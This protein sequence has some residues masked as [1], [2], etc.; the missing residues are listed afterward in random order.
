MFRDCP[1]VEDLWSSP[2]TLLSAVLTLWI[3]KNIS[4]LDNFASVSS[5]ISFNL[6]K[7]QWDL[8]NNY[9][10]NDSCSYGIVI[11]RH[12]KDERIIQWR[13]SPIRGKPRNCRIKSDV[14][15]AK[16]RNKTMR[17]ESCRLEGPNPT[18]W[19]KEMIPKLYLLLILTA[20]V[21]EYS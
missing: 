20:E 12:D 7:L 17:N 19:D 10:W 4:S 3:S 14:K 1:L 15:Q 11:F 18:K 16:A 2:A 21:Y 9:R 8:K 5:C 6:S 13:W